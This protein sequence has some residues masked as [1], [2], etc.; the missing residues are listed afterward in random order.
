MI[1][2]IQ[3]REAIAW[4]VRLRLVDVR[5]GN[6]HATEL[7][8]AASLRV[9]LIA[10]WIVSLLSAVDIHLALTFKLIR[11]LGYLENRLWVLGLRIRLIVRLARFL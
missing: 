11:V 6:Q 8:L 10:A 4:V 9:G 2:I 7:T 3:V 1:S 5:V